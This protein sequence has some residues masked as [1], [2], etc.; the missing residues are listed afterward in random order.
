M[1]EVTSE[2][3][4]ELLGTVGKLPAPLKMAMGSKVKEAEA[5]VKKLDRY[6]VLPTKYED[7]IVVVSMFAGTKAP[8]L[9]VTPNFDLDD[10]R[11]IMFTIVKAYQR[12]NPNATAQDLFRDLFYSGEQEEEETQKDD[13]EQEDEYTEKDKDKKKSTKDDETDNVPSD[14]SEAE[15][16]ETP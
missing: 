6:A 13:G 16:E 7:E 15:D 1:P 11:Y 10:L 12:L 2:A 8:P 9:K 5:F 14:D 3:K 4:K